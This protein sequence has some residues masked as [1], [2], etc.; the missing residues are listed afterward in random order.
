MSAS[1]T[2]KKDELNAFLSKNNISA[3]DIQ[4]FE[5]ENDI[6]CNVEDL[7]SSV[8]YLVG[9]ETEKKRK[10]GFFSEVYQADNKNPFL[11]KK[12]THSR[13]DLDT[14]QKLNVCIVALY[15]DDKKVM[16]SFDNG[17]GN[18]NFSPDEFINQPSLDRK[19]N[20]IIKDIKRKRE[21]PAFFEGLFSVD[22]KKNIRKFFR[23]YHEEDNSFNYYLYNLAHILRD[24]DGH[25]LQKFTLSDEDAPFSHDYEIIKLLKGIA[26]G[27]RPDDFLGLSIDYLQSVERERRA[28]FQGICD[29]LMLEPSRCFLFLYTLLL[30]SIIDFGS[31]ISF[32]TVITDKTR[33]P[34]I[35]TNK[36]A[37]NI[38]GFGQ[39]RKNSRKSRKSRKS[40]KSKKS[41]KSKKIKR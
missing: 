23:D 7:N 24:Y 35:E 29:E 25:T 33:L 19:F 2:G 13:L 26:T 12:M 30:H 34:Q 16:R 18:S 9:M 39:R 37:S 22:E 21:L 4:H 20:N 41:R 38:F 6:V 5:E 28:H 17:F 11:L 15:E 8:S 40:K 36:I 31:V 10:M 32:T 3:A 27:N 14:K 1:K